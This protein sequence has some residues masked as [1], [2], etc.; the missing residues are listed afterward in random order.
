MYRFFVQETQFLL[1]S[2]EE[3]GSL[4]DL[5][6][7]IRAMLNGSNGSMQPSENECWEWSFRDPMSVWTTLQGRCQ[8]I[9]AAGGIVRSQN[10]MLW[11]YRHDRWDWPKGKAESGESHQETALR[12]CEEE[13][14][15]RSLNI[16]D[17]GIA[18]ETHHLYWFQ[19]GPAWKTTVWYPM[20]CPM[21]R[22][23]DLIPQLEEGITR[24][25][26]MS[27]EESAEIALPKTYPS[28]RYLFEE[29]RRSWWPQPNWPDGKP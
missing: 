1:K 10:L 13:C 23:R 7:V 8:R 15:L 28:I 24:V 29:K 4:D 18:L 3:E 21:D 14:G 6:E 25:A 12:E 2:S 5:W 22:N 11:I 20:D 26:W 19:S 16:S 17:P 27:E 9:E